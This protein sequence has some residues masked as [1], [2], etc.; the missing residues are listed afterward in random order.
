[1]IDS[2]LKKKKINIINYFDGTWT[3]LGPR[4]F[5]EFRV[6]HRFS[7]LPIGWTKAC[8]RWKKPLPKFR[9]HFTI[10]LTKFIQLNP[11]FK[12]T[13]RLDPT[14]LNKKQ[15]QI[16]R[17]GIQEPW[18]STLFFFLDKLLHCMLSSIFLQF[19]ILINKTNYYS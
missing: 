17:F 18:N 10:N 15:Y 13:S 1:M 4:P 2:N 11:K 12:G 9:A 14:R 7:A 3:I 16:W 5:T 19:H 6:A 8:P